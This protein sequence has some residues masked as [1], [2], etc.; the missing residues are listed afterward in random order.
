MLS[1]L[2]IWRGTE[3]L[4]TSAKTGRLAF[5]LG[6]TNF[7]PFSLPMVTFDEDQ[8]SAQSRQRPT[9]ETMSMG[10]PSRRILINAEDSFGTIVEIECNAKHIGDFEAALAVRASSFNIPRPTT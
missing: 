5:I 3:D 4:T 9:S 10:K 1:P 8:E 2:L 6:D 7:P